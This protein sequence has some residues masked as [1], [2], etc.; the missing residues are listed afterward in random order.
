MKYHNW[1]VDSD[2]DETHKNHPVGYGKKFHLGQVEMLGHS[3]LRQHNSE[4]DEIER[5]PSS[6]RE[7]GGVAR[8]RTDRRKNVESAE[9]DSVFEEPGANHVGP[10]TKYLDNLRHYVGG[11]DGDLFGSSLKG[12]HMSDANDADLRNAIILTAKDD[13]LSQNTVDNSDNSTKDFKTRIYDNDSD[14]NGFMGSRVSDDDMNYRRNLRLL[15]RHPRLETYREQR[16][17]T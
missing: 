4:G 6:Y 12:S 11:I 2:N 10:L 1:Q 16:Q 3:A 9:K 17:V 5:V 7:A 15:P 14:E 8:S 13:N